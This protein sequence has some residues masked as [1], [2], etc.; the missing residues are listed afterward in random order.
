MKEIMQEIRDRFEAALVD[1]DGIVRYT[2]EEAIE[3]YDK[4]SSEVYLE[5]LSQLMNRN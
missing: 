2:A 4:I 1:E 3:I 5:K